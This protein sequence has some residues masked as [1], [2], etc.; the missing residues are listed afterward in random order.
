[1]AQKLSQN[2][3]PTPE[4]IDQL[5]ELIGLFREQ[6]PMM[7]IQTAHIFLLVARYPNMRASKLID[8][9]GLSQ[10]SVSRNIAA[11]SKINRHGTPGM[12]LIK[13][14]T[15]LL[16]PRAHRLKL[17]KKGKQFLSEITG[18]T[19]ENGCLFGKL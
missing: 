7:P 18:A 9:T 17:T 12:N 2:R 10:A 5:L 11:L 1:M 4:G 19:Q 15:D 14:T 13:Q 16:D 8:I 6:A 3:K